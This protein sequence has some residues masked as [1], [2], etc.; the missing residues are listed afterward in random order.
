MEFSDAGSISLPGG[1][2]ACICVLIPN[3][4]PPRTHL[5]TGTDVLYLLVSDTQP[6]PQGKAR[7][8]QQAA[9]P[10]HKRH[11]IWTP[12]Q[13]AARK[14]TPNTQGKHHVDQR[15]EELEEE[16]KHSKEG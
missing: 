12:S 9:A 3:P 13:P 4:P 16:D 5:P 7:H 8:R 14:H 10:Q 1:A 15:N 6:V 11:R 2:P